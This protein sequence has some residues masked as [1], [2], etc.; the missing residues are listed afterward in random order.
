MFRRSEHFLRK[1][2]EKYT[3]RILL[4]KSIRKVYFSYTFRKKC[5]DLR[6]ITVFSIIFVA[7]EIFKFKN[8]LKYELL[9]GSKLIK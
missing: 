4:A 6:N 5:S 1:V 9:M 2:Y 7:L 3:F 8:R